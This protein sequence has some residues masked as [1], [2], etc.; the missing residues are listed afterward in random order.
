MFNNNSQDFI[1]SIVENNIVG[2]ELDDELYAEFF[3]KFNERY[4]FDLEVH[5]FIKADFFDVD[6][7]SYNI[8][9]VR[10]NPPF[11][12]TFDRSKEDLL[13]RK[14]GKRNNQ[15]I[16]KETY[17]FFT[18]KCLDEVKKRNG[19]LKFICSDS[20]ITISTMKG[21][22]EYMLSIGKVSVTNLA[23]FSEETTWLTVY[24]HVDTSTTADHILIDNNKVE[25][26]YVNMV[27]NRSWSINED[28]EK[29]FSYGTFLSDYITCTSGMTV[30]N[31][32][33]WIK[34][35]VDGKIEEHYN[36]ELVEEPITLE[37]ETSRVRH[38]KFQ[39]TG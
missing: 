19:D 27:P 26:K 28:V 38:G 18:V 36:Y 39:A 5:N 14:Y 34:N 25:L 2:V 30:G 1:K 7:S 17:V 29:Y 9:K 24:F 15:K 31:N 20:F 8:N 37:K 12:G 4:G 23:D 11:G 6:I 3:D 13:D 22:R 35:V 10:G 16:K 21:F 32:E 33:L